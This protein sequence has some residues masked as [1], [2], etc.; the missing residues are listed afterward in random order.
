MAK[1]VKLG[2][3][4]RFGPRYGRKNKEKIASLENI[5]RNRQKC[6]FC[7]Y[8]KVK[9]LCQGIWQCGKCDAK[10]TGKAYYIEAAKKAKE[11]APLTTDVEEEYIEE[12][13]LPE[14]ELTDESEKDLEEPQEESAEDIQESAE[15]VAPEQETE[16]KIAPEEPVQDDENKVEA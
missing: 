1:K 4:K 8:V 10:F 5:H 2:S 11:K 14:E 12:E 9:R 15:E 16:E 7:N 3:T 6:P 13:D